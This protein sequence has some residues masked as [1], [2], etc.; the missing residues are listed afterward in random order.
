MRVRVFPLRHRGRRSGQYGFEAPQGI[1]G[2][3]GMHSMSG[4]QTYTI[5]TLRSG[6]PIAPELLPRLFEPVLVNIGANGLLLRGFEAIDGTSFV[7][8]WRCE[9]E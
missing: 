1:V 3:L 4:Q 7:Q 9:F 5:A 8:E 6:E 2:N